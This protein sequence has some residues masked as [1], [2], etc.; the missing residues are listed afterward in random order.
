M[1]KVSVV[2][3]AHN[4]P[5]LL[6]RAIKSVLAQTCQDFEIIVVDDGDVSVEDVV[7]SFSDSRVKYIKHKIPHKGGSAARNT[8]I[9]NSKGDYIAFLD[10]D[11]EYLPEKLEKQS[12]ILDKYFNK[13]GFVFSPVIKSREGEANKQHIHKLNCKE[14]INNFFESILALKTKILTPCIMIKKEEL[15]TIGGFDENLPSHQEWDLVIRLSKNCNGYFLNELVARAHHLLENHIGGDWSRRIKGR[16]MIIKKYFNELKKRP[17]AL[18]TH[19]FR[20]GT[21]YREN[22]NFKEARNYFLK[23]WRLDKSRL[24]LLLHF[25][26]VLFGRKSI[27][28]FRMIYSKYFKSI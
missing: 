4:R 9:K 8:G 3:P 23:A 15:L 2:I 26:S 14:G 27:H 5:K 25:I 6:K 17:E 12:Q 13:I 11:D 22:K 7:K 16:E 1:P 10:D 21:F 18:G 20:L 28:F 24:K 19:Y